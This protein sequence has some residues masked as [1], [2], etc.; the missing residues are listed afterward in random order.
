MLSIKVVT[1]CLVV[2]GMMA[3]SGARAANPVVVMETNMGN[4]KI[5][6]FE[7]KA[8]VTVKNFLKYAED[9]HY[10]GT[11]FHRVIEDFMIQG[12][13]FE[14]NMTQKKTR[15]P[16][17]NESDNGL[18]NVRGTIA[19]ARV[20]RDVGNVKA[21]DSATSQ[22]FINVKDNKGLDRANAGDKVGYCVFGRVIEG[23]DVVD[24]IRRVKTTTKKGHDDVPE[25]DVVIKS[26]KVAKS[27]K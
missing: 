1:V 5:E 23:M 11:I 26:V 4:I 9:K 2:L 8:P 20:G 14:P 27:E 16:I 24:K 12:G 21:A 6:L 25:D 13:G 3:A 18:S 22:F 17:K 7:D 10:D 19:M 15:D